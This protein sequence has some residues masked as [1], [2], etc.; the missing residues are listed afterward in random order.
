MKLGI[1]KSYA[2][3]IA[4]A[5]TVAAIAM[6]WSCGAS[7]LGLSSLKS[8]GGIG[9]DG[10]YYG[11]VGF[12]GSSIEPVISDGNFS[13]TDTGGSGVQLSLGRDISPRW[14]AEMY[15]SDLGDAAVSNGATGADGLINY[16]TIGLSGLF[17]LIGGGGSDALANRRGLNVY[18]RLGFGKLN[19]EGLGLNYSRDG[20]WNYSAGLGAEYNLRNGIGVRAEFQ[21]FDSDARVI[22]FNLI[23]RFGISKSAGSFVKFSGRGDDLSLRE[24][25][26]GAARAASLV[27]SDND[28]INDSADICNASEEGSSVDEYG[29]SFTGILEGV[30]FATGSAK[31]TD[32]GNAALD[33]VVTALAKNPNVRISVQA[34][35]DNRGSAERNMSLSR[36]RAET[37]V[38]YLIDSGE[39]DLDRMSAIGYGES[40]PHKSNKTKSGRQANRRVEIKIDR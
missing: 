24:P 26:I 34:H 1:G 13:V 20:G 22:S 23:K 33:G 31:L 7:A 2:S 14:S 36:K 21:N 8:L 40:R 6:T 19:N 30:T 18:G 37:V 15:Y 25:G 27:D 12:G 5:G 10:T 4:L 28:G 3:N 39:I 17:Y 9:V 29:C 11:G 35:T 16:S 32:G 38:R